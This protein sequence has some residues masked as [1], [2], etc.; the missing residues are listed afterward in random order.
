[1]NAEERQ[2]HQGPKE[3][4]F[5]EVT[6]VDGAFTRSA[7]LAYDVGYVVAVSSRLYPK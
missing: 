3:P 2:N 7:L 4:S 1:M 6:P 5:A